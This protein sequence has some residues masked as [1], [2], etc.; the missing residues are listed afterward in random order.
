[1]EGRT[2][3]DFIDKGQA[4]LDKTK[5]DV[6]VWGYREDN[7]IRFQSRVIIEGKPMGYGVANSKRES[8]QAAA[9]QALQTLK[10]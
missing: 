9:K 5:A 8:E 10:D 6:V 4:I 3:F 2:F 1:M 7:K